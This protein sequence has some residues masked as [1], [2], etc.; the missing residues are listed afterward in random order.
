MPSS[1]LARLKAL[2]ASKYIPFDSVLQTLQ[3][4]QATVGVTPEWE[5][6]IT[7][8][9]V[10]RSRAM[11]VR[12]HLK[13]LAE[14]DQGSTASSLLV[15]PTGVSETTIDALVQTQ[16]AYL[17]RRHAQTK[18]TKAADD[19]RSKY[20][21]EWQERAKLHSERAPVDMLSGLWHSGLSWRDIARL[22]K[23]SV[24]AVQKWRSGEK[25]SSKN[26]AHLRD[27]VAAYDTIAAHKPGVDIASWIDI[28][29][30]TDVPVTPRDI[31]VKGDPKLFFEYALG[32]MKPETVLDAFDPDWRR[33]Y[34]D[35]GFEA[36]VGTDG[37][38]GIRT[39]DR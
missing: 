24:A 25:M 17:E 28:P 34:R 37:V 38:L 20:L 36:F 32:D 27:F 33:R 5:G 23:V 11:A 22:L 35:D 26:F 21:L 4:W 14:L 7:T 1:E 6:R 31:W 15:P 9:R 19:H 10:R 13:L 2:D 18:H 16:D 29:I 8:H 39:K 12:D 30:L 3:E